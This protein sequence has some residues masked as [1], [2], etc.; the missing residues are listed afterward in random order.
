MAN[1][2]NTATLTPVRNLWSPS[3]RRLATISSN[4]K[5]RLPT[6]INRRG[7]SVRR[8]QVARRG[9]IGRVLIVPF[10]PS[11]SRWL[12]QGTARPFMRM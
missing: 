10:L 12:V 3:D 8:R 4:S 5:G 9:D 6:A 7:I 2:M 11:Q 1:A